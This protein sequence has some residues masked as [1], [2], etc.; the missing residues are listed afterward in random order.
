MK[1]EKN[2]GFFIGSVLQ[3]IRQHIEGR[4]GIFSYRVK[5][6]LWHRNVGERLDD[7]AGYG[8]VRKQRCPHPFKLVFL[9]VRRLFGQPGLL[10]G[11]DQYTTAEFRQVACLP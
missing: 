6:N 8:T 4:I 11:E 5:R 3:K 10:R 2:E 1:A 9:L 7:L